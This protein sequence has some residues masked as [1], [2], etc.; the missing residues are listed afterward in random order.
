MTN[1]EQHLH[2]AGDP[3]FDAELTWETESFWRYRKLSDLVS[4]HGRPFTADDL[5]ELHAEASLPEILRFMPAEDTG[6]S[7]RGEGSTAGSD[8]RTLWHCLFDQETGMVSYRFYL[9]DKMT[10]D[11]R[12]DARRS[13]YLTFTLEDERPR[14]S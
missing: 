5:K 3:L 13:D 8:V 1:F 4:A 12:L 6:G 2:L 10:D 7:P 14:V 11:G 9:G